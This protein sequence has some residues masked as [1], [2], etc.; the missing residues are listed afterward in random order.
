MTAR[1][2][3]TQTPAPAP[4]APRPPW[5]RAAYEGAGGAP[6][7]PE[8]S[9]FAFLNV[10]LARPRLALGLP[11]VAAV[12]AVAASLI[13]PATF[14]AVTTFAPEGR[15]QSR[16]GGA[17]AGG[18]GALAGQLGISFTA[19][20]SQSPRFYASV[21]QSRELLER[22]LLS[23]YPDPRPGAS[24]ADSVTLLRMLGVRGRNAADSLHR[25]VKKLRRRVSVGVENQTSIVTLAVDSHY[26]ALAAAVANRFVAYLNDFNTETRQSQAR[27]RRRFLEQR[28][29]DAEADLRAAEDALPVFYERNRSWQQSPE[30]VAQDARLRRQVEMRQEVYLTLRRQY[31]TARMDEVNDTPVITVVDAAVA[32]QERSTPVWVWAVVAL[33]LGAMVGVL[34]AF[35]IHWMERVRQEEASD[36]EE[37]STLLGQAIRALRPTRRAR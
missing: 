20:P 5:A 29:T 33:V 25:G 17:E 14:T 13:L 8:V 19:D 31:E 36:Y 32:P 30:L 4:A 12:L 1:E 27:E 35:A 28:L 23:R 24:A 34:G 22:V 6:P 15:S 37:F 11:L 2:P 21:V 18:L 9:V 7:E 26:P 10:L 16:G 3:D